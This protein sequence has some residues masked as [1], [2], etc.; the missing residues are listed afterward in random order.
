MRD[1]RF[2]ASHRGGPLFIE[3]HRLLALWAAECAG[4]VIRRFWRDDNDRR[5]S[6]AVAGAEAWARGENSVGMA[7]KLAVAA[8]A[9]AREAGDAAS[10]AGARAAGHAAGTAHMADH[11]LAAAEYALRAVELGGGDVGKERAWQEQRLPDAVRDLVVS[12]RTLKC[13]RR[14]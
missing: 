10:A 13:G 5:P 4:R 7:R 2:V 8:H 1:R 3:D 14:S 12:A 9:A 11:C 6:E